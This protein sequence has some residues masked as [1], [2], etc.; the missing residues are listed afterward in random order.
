[1]KLNIKH[2]WNALIVVVLI[3]TTACGQ[4]RGPRGGGQGGGEQGPP[5]IPTTKQIV[6]M[7]DKL[8]SEI[9]LSEDQKAEVLELYKEHFEEVEDLTS[10]GRPD[11]D[12]MEALKED[13]ESDVNE[14]L[15]EDQ[16]K[17]YKAY[18]KKNSRKARK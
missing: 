14:V 10:D 15:T 7:V 2:I 16:Q 17:L 13:F 4:Q 11:R 3:T 8:S 9:L 6:K 5:P 18:V 12:K 1:M